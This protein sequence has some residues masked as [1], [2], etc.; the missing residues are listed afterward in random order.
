MIRTIILVVAVYCLVHSCGVN[1]GKEG[2]NDIPVPIDER[3]FYEIFVHAYYD[4]NGD[5]IGDLQG[6]I[7]KLDYL[8]ELGANG[9]W[10]LPVH[11][12]PSYHKYDVTD[13]YGIHPDYGTMEDMKLLLA[14]AHERDILVLI[15]M[16]I[17]HT[18]S[19]HP[20]FT[21]A[22]EGKNNHFRDYY[23][24]SADT[25][26]QSEEPYH[27]HA[28]GNDPEKY[29]GFFWK[30]MPDLNFDNPEVRKE[31]KKIGAWW[32]EEVGVDG[33][34]LDA[35]KYIY[36][37][38]LIEKNVQWWQE[39]RSSLESTGMDFFM[40]AEIWDG[41]DF[42]APFLNG[43]VDAA[44]DF[45]LSFAI[46]EMLASGEDPGLGELLAGI[47]SDYRSASDSWHDAIFLKNHDQDR[48]MS[49][50]GDPR[51]AKLAASVLFTLPGIPFIYYGE[52]IGMP[53]KK[54][55]EYIREP[56][57]WDLPGQDPGQTR[58]IEPLY[59]K[60]GKVEPV[61]QQ[62]EDPESLLSHYKKMIALRQEHPLLASG[63]ISG[64][65]GMPGH[66]CGYKISG[67]KQKIVV[68]H[69][70]TDRVVTLDSG[71]LEAVGPV[72][73]LDGNFSSGKDS[74]LLEPFGSLVR[75]GIK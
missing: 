69:N 55:D 70:L 52:E 60:P 23:V 25:L 16:V 66:L 68:L 31:M 47:R 44:F 67:K 34:R 22:R 1:Q 2:L 30:G 36:P 19:E 7:A 13:Y 9:I 53:G 5:G 65:K 42:I 21:E 61:R 32:L 43:G 75:Y 64:L 58:W 51:Q 46:E 59:S 28:N 48:I 18:S 24:W 72:L 50:L 6:V 29:Y 39:Y 15:D 3:V 4:S 11:P 41:A 27:W 62:L 38:S 37:D 40:V 74:L 20:F 26:L 33:F 71:V 56:M 49:L 8:K 45:D 54:P 57:V 17:N 35:I 10:L 14:E 12:S 63:S 73:H